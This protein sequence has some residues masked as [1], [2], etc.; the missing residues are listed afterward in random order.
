MLFDVRRATAE[1]T[2]AS[3]FAIHCNGAPHILFWRADTGDRWV[4][5]PIGAPC[6]YHPT[7]EAAIQSLAGPSA[8]VAV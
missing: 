2:T 4:T 5:R 6:R 1:E 3:A 7:L 8:A